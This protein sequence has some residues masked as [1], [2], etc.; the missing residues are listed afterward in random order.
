[1]A[2]QQTGK[3]KP[4]TPGVS[5]I[6]STRRPIFFENLFANYERQLYPRKELILILNNNKMDLK[7]YRAEAKYYPEVSVYRMDEKDS[8]GK[9]LNFAVAKSKYPFVAKFDD[10]DYYSPYYL[11]GVVSCFRKN[12]ADVVGKNT[13]FLYLKSKHLLLLFHPKRTNQFTDLLMGSTLSFRKRVFQKMKFRDVSRG[14]DT[15]FFQDCAKH[16]IKLFSC[17][18]YNYVCIRR[19]NRLTHT[20]TIDE[21]TILEH[22]EKVSH[23][24]DFARFI[25]KNVELRTKD[26]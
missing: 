26:K 23:T 15:F 7:K 2:R 6:V 13:C 25:T 5:V 4:L 17:D 14:E 16:N 21:K 8:L 1:M 22:S 18:P 24:M 9:C 20:W 11:N 12:K 3:R 19:M 10:D